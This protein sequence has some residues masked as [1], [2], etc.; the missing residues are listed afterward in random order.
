M[1]EK[2]HKGKERPV[3]QYTAVVKIEWTQ[4]GLEGRNKEEAKE[5]L[6]N[7]FEEEFGLELAE[8]EILEI[9]EDK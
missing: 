3:K 8:H 7:T 5:Q 6:R 9:R 1:S 2:R 4:A